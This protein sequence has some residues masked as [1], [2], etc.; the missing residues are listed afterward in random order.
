[1]HSLDVVL[2]DFTPPFPNHRR[3]SGAEGPS[4]QGAA[5]TVDM[6]QAAQRGCDLGYVHSQADAVDSA[7][8]GQGLVAGMAPP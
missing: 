7:V 4:Q 1:M 2:I 6:D 3:S 5:F 8:G